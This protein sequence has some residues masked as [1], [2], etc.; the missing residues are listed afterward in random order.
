MLAQHSFF[1]ALRISL[2]SVRWNIPYLK[3]VIVT[4]FVRLLV[5]T[6]IHHMSVKLCDRLSGVRCQR[7]VLFT[8]FG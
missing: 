6:N 4:E 8:V 2:S 3:C 7:N 5:H 1:I